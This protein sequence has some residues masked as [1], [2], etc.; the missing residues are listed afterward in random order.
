M[1]ILYRKYH[2]KTCRNSVSTCRKNAFLA[3]K[4]QFGVENLLTE[5]VQGKK[6]FFETAF[7]IFVNLLTGSGKSLIYQSLLIVADISSDLLSDLPQNPRG[8]SWR[9][10]VAWGPRK[11]KR[12]ET[13]TLVHAGVYSCGIGAWGPRNRE[14]RRRRNPRKNHAGTYGP[15]I[16]AWGPRKRKTRRDETLRVRVNDKV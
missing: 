9:V 4:Q 10:D 3:I 15:R 14:T 16:G 5:Q 11:R 13:L 2:N 8:V 1:H 12:G 6:V 7:H